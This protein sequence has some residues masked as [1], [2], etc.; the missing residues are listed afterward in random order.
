MWPCYR[1]T[2]KRAIP[3]AV[4]LVAAL[5][6]AGCGGGDDGGD[7]QTE[8]SNLPAPPSGKA[9]VGGTVTLDGKPA[10][11]NSVGLSVG[12]AKAKINVRTDPSG[13]FVFRAVQPGKYS[14]A[15]AVVAKGRRLSETGIPLAWDKPCRA[16]GYRV[17]NVGVA[18]KRTGAPIGVIATASSDKGFDVKAGD[19]LTRNIAFACT[20]PA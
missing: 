9:T 18:S 20:P 6:F 8:S 16:A 1:G 19:R 13:N 2:G 5:S 3:P 4:L 7:G 15:V 14:V 10:S 11:R 17:L 12:G